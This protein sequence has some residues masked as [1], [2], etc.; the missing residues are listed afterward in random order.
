M[1]TS[2][3]KETDLDP[4]GG[5]TL[6]DLGA[7]SLYNLSRVSSRQLFCTLIILL[8]LTVMLCL[9]RWCA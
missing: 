2:I 7:S 6:E 1:V 3:I 9:R 8:V 5:Q 4:Y